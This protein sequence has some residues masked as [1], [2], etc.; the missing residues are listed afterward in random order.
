MSPPSRQLPLPLPVENA[1]EAE[2]F[3]VAN[4]NRDAVAWIN[5]WP[6]WPGQGLVVHGPAASGK[7]HLASI[8]TKRVNAS[9]LDVE[10][11]STARC[12]EITEPVLVDAADSCRNEDALFHLLNHVRA[13]GHSV[14]LTGRVPPASWPVRLPDLRSRLLALPSVAMEPPDDLLLTQLAAKLFADRQIT[15]SDEVIGY[16][17]KRLERS[18]AAFAAA[19]EQLDRAALAARRPVTVPLARRVLELDQHPNETD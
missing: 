14:L 10:T 18:C 9:V 12:L 3:V 6:D 16:M 13:Q 1:F 7:S 2:E 11:L 17:L 19:V 5:A 8:W 4:S 15:V